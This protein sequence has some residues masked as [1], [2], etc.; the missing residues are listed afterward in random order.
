MKNRER[1]RLFVKHYVDTGNAEQSAR[2]AGYSQAKYGYELTRTLSDEIRAETVRRIN[3]LAPMAISTLTALAAQSESDA[4]KR[5]AAK[6]LLA[7][8]GYDIQRTED[9]TQRDTRT[10]DELAQAL[11]ELLDQ[12]PALQ[13]AIQAKQ[14]GKGKVVDLEAIRSV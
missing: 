13:K 9:V 2:M 10:D 1:Q 6:D 11:A 3:S 12:S 4:V 7:L 8:G 5:Q 14:I